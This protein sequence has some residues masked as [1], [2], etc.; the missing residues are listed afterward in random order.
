MLT[1]LSVI[2]ARISAE[3]NA[4]PLKTL[5]MEHAGRSLEQRLKKLFTHH[6]MIG[7][8]AWDR[9][10][11]PGKCNVIVEVVANK[12]QAMHYATNVIMVGIDTSYPPNE[13]DVISWFYNQNEE[14]KRII[15]KTNNDNSVFVPFN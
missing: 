14:M 7:M 12:K 4:F 15:S 10:P 1:A 5:I 9:K 3:I 11:V 6:R 8:V 2:E 13:Q